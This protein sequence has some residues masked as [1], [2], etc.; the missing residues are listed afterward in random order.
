MKDIVRTVSVTGCSGQCI[1]ALGEFEPFSDVL[2]GIVSNPR[3]AT[4]RL[5]KRHNDQS[6]TINSCEPH[7][8]KYVLKAEDFFKYAK[9]ID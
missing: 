8:G 6:I 7:I 3:Q 5:R 2:E 1:N 9:E 4:A